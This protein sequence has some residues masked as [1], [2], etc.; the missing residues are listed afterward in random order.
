VHAG[1][2][3][4]CRTT[5]IPYPLVRAHELAVVAQA[6]RA[7]L[8]QLLQAAMLRVGLQTRISQ[9]AQTKRWTAQRRRHRL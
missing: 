9:K 8:E 2:L 1:V 3:E 4:Q 6:D 5:G 7:A